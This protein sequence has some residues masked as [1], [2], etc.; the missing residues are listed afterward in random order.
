METLQSAECASK[1]SQRALRSGWLA[2]EEKA[3]FFK[4]CHQMLR[5]RLKI[6]STLIR[7]S[8]DLTEYSSLRGGGKLCAPSVGEIVTR[9]VSPRG[10]S[11]VSW[12]AGEVVS[13]Q[14]QGHTHRWPSV[15]GDSF[16]TH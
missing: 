10:E 3:A 2:K 8:F 4:H 7:F 5:D 14:I 12:Q 16:Y 11:R 1:S 9:I 13:G 15:L 6:H